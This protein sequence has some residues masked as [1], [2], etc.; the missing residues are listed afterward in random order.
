[1]PEAAEDE[2]LEIAGIP[3]PDVG[4]PLPFVVASEERLF[5]SYFATAR[6]PFRDG[7]P[8]CADSV[9]SP[10]EPIVR[11]EFE[12]PYCH[13]FGPPNDE[14]LHGHP[15][16][17]RGLHTSSVSEVR[18]SSWLRA[19]EQRNAVHPHHDASFFDRLRHFVFTFHDSTFEC[20]ATGLT[21]SLHRG[22]RSLEIVR[23]ARELAG[24]EAA[25]PDGT[26]TED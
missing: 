3:R 13:R 4:A 16:A 12:R 5:L 20:A 15:L 11:V 2:V 9:D 8:S 26:S 25:E 17:S 23:V 1:M 14:T 21:S 7:S 24:V 19:L 18:R 6:D 22:P 10:D